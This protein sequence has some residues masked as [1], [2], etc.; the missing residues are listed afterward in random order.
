MPSPCPVKSQAFDMMRALT[1]RPNVASSQGDQGPCEDALTD[2]VANRGG[3]KPLQR[4]LIASNGMAAA[5]AM[6]SLR[7]WAHMEAGL[8]SGVAT[9]H[10]VAMATREDLD[11]NADY[12]RLADSFVEVPAGKNVNNYANVD[13]ICKIAKSEAVQAVWP[14]WGHA[15]ENPALPSKLKELGIA[16]IGPTSSVM[17]VLGDKIAAGILA[18]TA[19]VPSI[20]WSGDGLKAE[21]TAEGTIPAETFKKALLSNVAE[22]ALCAERIGYPVVLKASE[23]GGGKGIRMSA[24]RAEL[25]QHFPQVQGEVPGSPIFM[26]QLC[27][28]ARHIEVQIVGD[29]H[30][31]VL[32]LSGRDCSTQRRFQKIFEEGPPV[33]VPKDKFKEMERAAQRLTQNIGYIGAGTVE[34]LYDAKTNKFY[35]LELNPRL[36]VEHPV[37]EAITQVNL[38]ATQ[39]QIAMGIPLH[40]MPQIRRFYGKADSD[41]DSPIDFMVEDYVYPKIHCMAARITAENPDDGFKPTSG[42]IERIKFQ[43]SVACWGYFSVWTHAAIHE[44]ADSQFGHL[45]A[46]GENRDEARK[47]LVLALQNL[48]IVGEI[49]NPVD[50]LVELLGTK[51]FAQNDIDTSWLDGLIKAKSV[52]VKYDKFDVV[53]YAA[54]VRAVRAAEAHHAEMLD[55]VAKRRVGLLG[56]TRGAQRQEMEIAFE[57]KKYSFLVERAGPDLY[58]LSVAGSSIAAKVRV[59]P[60]T[61]LLVTVGQTVMKISG[62]EEP[63]GLRLRIQGVGTVLLPTLF[64]PSELRSEFNG[65]IIR[66]LQADGAVVQEGELY[67]ELEAM[68]MIMPLKATATGKIHFCK[69][70]GSVVIAGELLATM[71]LADPAG[72]QKLEPFTKGFELAA[73]A[74]AAASSSPPPPAGGDAL[75][76]ALLALDGFVPLASPKELAAALFPSTFVSFEFSSTPGEHDSVEAQV[77]AQL[78]AAKQVLESY[79]RVERRFAALRA[80]GLGED[81]AVASLIE[82]SKD[83]AGAVA[84][85]LQAHSQLAARS[86]LV[87]ASLEA[88]LQLPAHSTP[89]AVVED[90]DKE[91][92]PLKLTRAESRRMLQSVRE[93]GNW[94]LVAEQLRELS[95]LPASCSGYSEVLLLARRLCQRLEGQ[96]WPSRQQALK[97]ALAE[98][99]KD[100]DAANK[101]SNWPAHTG[102]CNLLVSL[103]GDESKEVRGK[104]LE[105]FVRRSYRAFGVSKDSKIRLADSGP[106]QLG[107]RW[108]FRH[109]GVSSGV[110]S[111]KGTSTWQ[112]FA[113]VVPDMEGLKAFLATDLCLGLELEGSNKQVA[114]GALGRLHLFLLGETSAAAAV[115]GAALDALLSEVHSLL[116][117]VEAKLRAVGAC[118]VVLVLPRGSCDEPRFAC[119]AQRLSW[120]EVRTFRDL[121]PTTPCLLEV[122]SLAEALQLEVARLAPVAAEA[123]SG[124]VEVFLA[125]PLV[126]QLQAAAQVRGRNPKAGKT[127]LVRIASHSR[128]RFSVQ[129]S[130][131]W[132]ARLEAL[133]LSAVHELECARLSPQARAADGQLFLHLTAL[134][135]LQPA[136]LYALLEGFIVEFAARHG[137]LLQQLWVDEITL[138]VRL[139]NETQG[140][141][142]ILRFTASSVDGQYM[143]CVGLL[144]EVDPVTGAP[145]RWLDLATG[146]ASELPMA[147][148]DAKL[149]AKRAAAR[150]AGSTYAPEFL[151]LLEAGLVKQWASFSR[152]RP[153]EELLGAISKELLR[154]TELLLD[155][156]SELREASEVRKPGAND[157]GMLAWR[158]VL[159]TPE[160]P[161]G[162]SVVLIANDVTHQAG[163]FGVAE[164][165]F[166]Q[167]ASEYARKR[168]LPR[169]YVACNSGARVGLVEELMPKLRVKW[170][171]PSDPSKGFDYL[172]LSEE[173]YASLPAGAVLAKHIPGVGFILEAVVGTGL[174]SVAGGIGVENLQ[175]SGL[176]A[177]ETSRAYN[178]IFTLSYVTGRSVGIGAYLNRLGQRTIQCVDGPMVLTG[179]SALNK[180]LGQE[181]YS[182]QDQLGGPQIMVPNGVTHQLVASDSEGA[183]AILRWLSFVPRD[184]WSAPACTLPLDPPSRPVEFVP[185]KQPYDPRHMLAGTTAADGAWVGGFFDRGSFQEYLAG[186]GRSVVVGRARLGGVP[187]GVIAVET[188][189]VERRIP[190]DPGNPESREIVESQAGQVW[191][192]DSAFKTATAIRDF[193]RGENLPLMIF[194]NWRGFS[195]GTRDMYSEVLKFGAQIVD[196]LV[197]YKHPVFIYI[198]PGGEL[199]GGSWVVVDPTINPDVME[200]YA[201]VESRGGILE[202]AGIVEVKFR[203]QQR[204]ELMHRLDAKLLALKA[205]LAAAGGD[206]A[207]Q[208][209]LR[210]QIKRREE[211]LQPVYTQVACE[212]ADLHDRSGRMKAVG[213]VRDS[214]EWRGSREFFYWRLRRCLAEQLLS[215]DLQAADP[216]LG[217]RDAQATVQGWLQQELG[218]AAADNR[219]VVEFLARS[220]LAGRVRAAH[221]GAQQRRI[222]Q[223]RAELEAAGQLTGARRCLFTCLFP[224]AASPWRA[225]LGGSGSEAAGAA[226]GEQ[227]ADVKKVAYPGLLGGGVAQGSGSKRV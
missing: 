180:L 153:Q 226:P 14:G 8:S 9:F 167:K 152:G 114:A 111:S 24:S 35:F 169:I 29:Q 214:L 93:E 54:V 47:T 57:G 86:E 176:I 3:S 122:A 222:H 136:E 66:Y 211:Q 18:Q 199:R 148:P 181:V 156:E 216:S 143:K 191:F 12:V 13:L 104:A 223:L 131:G 120:S 130:G 102:G 10:F 186:W 182:S 123:G 63:L 162:R 157:I 11:A 159:K 53:F 183:E 73:H 103:L 106:A 5:K 142:A 32:A 170:T 45:F 155:G 58:V 44:Y 2:Y 6:I 101:I 33:I 55:S 197:E 19:G 15:S 210:A 67:V 68:K 146:A 174:A 27:T 80:E 209:E 158:C 126:S 178:E 20:P 127:V 190:A 194:A 149:Q 23:G 217:T 75:A 105:A 41:K 200:M 177:G 81:L 119:F 208:E 172:Y 43:S 100:E 125:S 26:M 225:L 188:R 206:A 110:G 135:N 83:D 51:A 139:G 113:K 212:F 189:N 117:A 138:K 82:D 90:D 50:Y 118:E 31:K 198:P 79:L 121:G 171:E 227:R 168:G 61:S 193:N 205:S 71:V 7:Q 91:Q 25:E 140:C 202:P 36:Q 84:A 52:K 145:A 78:E 77:G 95:E 48:E 116:R 70:P 21:L 134:V 74:A 185:T 108:S 161:T 141:E 166:F 96:P 49:R 87:A 175:G 151:G 179:Y 42:K 76:R 62:S 187:M 165:V 60:D 59:Q 72:G 219:Q 4:I 56:K 147:A 150:R 128:L 88:L 22:A 213:A 112:G 1:P 85:L 64:D 30:G 133:L 154:A 203:A 201:D 221:A 173:D 46:R 195:G 160:Y 40:R 107:A 163:S 164:D 144:E 39:I 218:D 207:M 224:G 184:S 94:K 137:A 115:G 97:V 89:T 69:G 220:P 109:P 99:T 28:G 17:S 204:A 192:P 37:T 98:R 196:A 215:R 34:Y 129:E 92:P 65:K 38:P 132:A 16:F 124:V